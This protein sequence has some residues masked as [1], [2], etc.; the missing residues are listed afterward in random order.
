MYRGVGILHGEHH[1]RRLCG[2]VVP[3]GVE[4]HDEVLDVPRNL[5]NVER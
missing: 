5:N 3:S 4:F 2:V 1:G